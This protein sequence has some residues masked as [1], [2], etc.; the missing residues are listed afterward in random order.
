[1]KVER[2][3]RIVGDAA[4]RMIANSPEPTTRIAGLRRLLSG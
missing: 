1:M 4:E 3:Q 2:N